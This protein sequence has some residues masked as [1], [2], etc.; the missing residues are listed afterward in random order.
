MGYDQGS[1]PLPPRIP[2][3]SYNTLEPPWVGT[4]TLMTLLLCPPRGRVP[5]TGFSPAPG[6][7]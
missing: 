3:I 5:V 7:T 6:I 2:R 4:L 1:A